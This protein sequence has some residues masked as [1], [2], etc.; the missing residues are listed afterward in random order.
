MLTYKKEVEEPRLEVRYDS[1]SESPRGDSNIGVFVWVGRNS[2]D[3][4]PGTVYKEA[5]LYTEIQATSTEHHIELMKK[6]LEADS[7]GIVEI[8][9][10]HKYEHGNVVYGLGRASG[11]DYSNKGFYFVLKTYLKEIL[12]TD[13]VEPR[14]VEQIISDELEIYTKWANGE[15]YRYTLLDEQGEEED[16][17][18]GFY[19]LAS[20]KEYLPDDFHEEDLQDYFKSNADG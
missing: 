13:T 3:P 20:M 4:E 16:S 5:V 12:G 9:P 15:V 18:G 2:I 11:F 7:D 19:D 8:Y 6:Y 10:V 17:C 14:E 1:G